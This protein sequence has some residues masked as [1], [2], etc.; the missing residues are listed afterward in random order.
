MNPIFEIS[1]LKNIEIEFQILISA[2]FS[3]LAPLGPQ[4]FD[5]EEDI[6]EK[7]GLKKLKEVG[8]NSC[9]SNFRNNFI[10][11]F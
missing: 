10:P 9:E 8:V 7:S 4:D 1:N 3:V 6:L 2:K 5:S 11:R